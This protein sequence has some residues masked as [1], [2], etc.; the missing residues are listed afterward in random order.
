[1][2]ELARWL[3]ELHSLSAMNSAL[4]ADQ[5]IYQNETTLTNYFNILFC[6]L[7]AF[8]FKKNWFLNII[9]KKVTLFHWCRNEDKRVIHLFRLSK[10]ING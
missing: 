9:S 4:L 2:E 5:N 6:I 7:T 10:S 1:M 8:Y 3:R